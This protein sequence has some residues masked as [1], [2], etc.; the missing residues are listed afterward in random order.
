V[1]TLIPIAP[2][3]DLMGKIPRNGTNKSTLGVNSE[4]TPDST[5]CQHVAL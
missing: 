5:P 4:L 2:N 3:V 1:T